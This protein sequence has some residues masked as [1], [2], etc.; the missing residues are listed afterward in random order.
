[1][2]GCQM[3]GDGVKHGCQGSTEPQLPC[4]R[5]SL[6]KQNGEGSRPGQ[7]EEAGGPRAM[8]FWREEEV[9]LP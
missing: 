4:S 6:I 5:G 3:S 8:A 1:M 7:E 9:G 2:P